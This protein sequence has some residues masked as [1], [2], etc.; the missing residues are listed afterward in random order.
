LLLWLWWPTPTLPP[1]PC[2]E[3]EDP[4]VPVGEVIGQLY[5]FSDGFRVAL[6]DAAN[7]KLAVAVLLH[8]GDHPLESRTPP[9][10]KEYLGGDPIGDA[11]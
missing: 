7:V 8:L 6:G 1:P 3:E 5:D 10:G 2:C 4:R 11:L 9:N